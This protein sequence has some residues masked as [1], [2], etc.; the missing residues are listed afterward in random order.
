MTRYNYMLSAMKKYY[1]SQKATEIA[2][3]QID[4]NAPYQTSVQSQI[5]SNKLY[6]NV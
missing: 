3:L 1:S 4:G 2:R 5:Y 6:Y